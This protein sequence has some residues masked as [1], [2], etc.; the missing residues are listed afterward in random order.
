MSAP[1]PTLEETRRRQVRHLILG[2]AF[3]AVL[4][5]TAW[6]YFKETD[7]AIPILNNVVVFALVNLNIILLMLLAL[8]IFRNLV[9]L[10]FEHKGKKLAPRFQVKLVA[11][12]VGFSLLP[13]LLLFLVA[14]GLINK[15]VDTWFSVR[16]EKSLRGSLEVAQTYYRSTER[17]LLTHGEG[18]AR[19]IAQ[20]GLLRPERAKVLAAQL[21]EDGR[22]FLLEGLWVFDAK[23][24]ELASYRGPQLPRGFFLWPYPELIDRAMGG[25]KTTQVETLGA[26]DAIHA[27]VP[28]PGDGRGAPP[29]GVVVLTRYA[30]E[31]LAAKL[32][33]ISSTFMNYKQLEFSKNP[34]KASYIITFLL[35]ALLILFSAVWF[36][37]YLARGI[38]VP[39]EKLAEGT[40]AVAEGNLDHRVEVRANDEVGIL[41]DAFNQM[42]ADLAHSVREVEEAHRGLQRTNYELEE[43]RRYME[44]V[45]ENIATGVI[46]IDRRGRI[47]TLNRAAARMLEVDRAQAL[48]RSYLSVFAADQLDPIRALIKRMGEEEVEAATQQLQL[49]VGGR[50]L[51]LLA[52][53]AMLRDGSAHNLGLVVV[54]EDLTEL[55]RAQKVAAWREVAQGIAHEIKNPLTPIQLS[56]QRLR[57]KFREGA[58]DFAGVFETCTETIVKQVEG[59]RELVNEFSRFARMPAPRPRPC[60]L[61]ATLRET[62]ALYRNSHRG[63]S[64]TT[65]FELRPFQLEADEEQLKRAFINLIDNAVDAVEG[66]GRVTVS[67]RLEEAT[68]RVRIAVADEGKGVPAELRPRLFLPYFS[69]KTRGTGL[70]LAI[71]QRIVA[72][73]EGTIQVEDNQ[74]RGTVFVLNLPL[75]SRGLPAPRPRRGVAVG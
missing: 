60:D 30:P 72:D 57:K 22:L 52:S 69:T 50:V 63:V 23:K 5:T 13:T 19:R 67:T 61:H 10:Y 53:V 44:T 1:A 8:L 24:K 2:L 36:G 32:R 29:R 65:D 34:I 11:A 9:K 4:A 35:V 48:G 6:L 45:L 56:T 28:I 37:F 70:G 49:A 27:L 15:S 26:A 58:P 46:S 47:S 33:N 25:E 68:Q 21:Q 7:P 51:T 64:F 71:V 18:I 43:R 59:L 42:T 39:I 54:F 31:G 74:P 73:H 14:S 62:L 17:A 20:E 38:T 3:A 12:F 41:V 66:R 55:I 16:V 75:R 40:R